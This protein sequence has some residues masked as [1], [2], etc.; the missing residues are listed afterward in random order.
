MTLSTYTAEVE[1]RGG[2]RQATLKGDISLFAEPCLEETGVRRDSHAMVL[3]PTPPPS[4]A[5]FLKDPILYLT[6]TVIMA[7][8]KNYPH[9]FEIPPGALKT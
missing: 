7:S 6:H 3:P 8:F 4:L 5:I 9:D 1:A 2:W